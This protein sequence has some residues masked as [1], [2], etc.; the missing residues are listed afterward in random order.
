[1]GTLN[2]AIYWDDDLRA[3][4]N[5]A[6]ANYW[7]TYT[8][9]ICDQM[10]LSAPECSRAGLKADSLASLAVLILPDLD[11]KYLQSP[12][13]A[14]LRDWVA[15]GGLLIGFA[16]EGLGDLFGV[17]VEGEVP[18]A[19]DCYSL[20]A[21]L[22]FS[23]AELSRPLLPPTEEDTPIPIAAPVKLLRAEAGSR[24]LVQLL[25]L[26][27]RDLRRPAVTLREVGQGQA[28]YFGFNV[29]HSVWVMHH[30]RPILDDFD[31][32][33]M[34][35]SS[36]A[37]ILRPFSTALP[38]A[39]L[40]VMLLR[41]VIGRRG[42]PFIHAL[43]PL[44]ETG[45]VPDALFHWGGDD[46][47]LAGQQVPASEF[48]R[49]LGLPYHINIMARPGA[50]FSLSKAEYD[51]LKANGH[52]PSLHFNF[53]D[54][55]QH[56][57]SFTRQDIQRQ[58]DEYVAAFGET[59]VCSVFHCTV[60]NLWHE[61]AEWMA[62][63]GLLGDNGHIHQPCPPANPI[64]IVGFGF[65]TGYPYHFYQDWRK[66]NDRIRFLE[67]PINAYECGYWQHTEVLDL[68]PL[69]RAVDLARFW[70]TTMNMF[71][72]PVLIY[73][74]P[75]CKAA[76]KAGLEYMLEIGLKP[77]HMGNDGLTHWWLA[78]SEANIRDAHR[79]SEG[80]DMTVHANWPDGVVVQVL[81]NSP[82][83]QATVDGQPQP[84]VVREEHGACWLYVS[85]PQGMHEVRVW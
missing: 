76:I 25:S 24:A 5:T 38:Y 10:G 4:A 64:N 31:G 48:M 51:Q 61:P 37:M 80:R 22:R 9:E 6:G 82:D 52:E 12:E 27:G 54:G 7:H 23:D 44:P 72:H 63:C 78:R 1:M 33:G 58:V 36:D 18:Q 69:H 20:T 35:R 32:D 84:T 43:P 71:Y 59:P 50:G 30:G 26:F 83:A 42:V 47:A 68:K 70:H 66:D 75:Q 53:I 65:G 14:A 45:E 73:G 19:E 17:R 16:T 29:A 67:L 46:E 85:V 56:P 11:A 41:N 15:A 3:Q 13:K 39:D 8:R 60:W 55:V 79:A 62:S 21:A 57:Y 49:G 77:I 74:F 40:L 81:V 2:V 28:M 34:L